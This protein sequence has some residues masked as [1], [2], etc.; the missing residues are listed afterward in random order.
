MQCVNAAQQIKFHSAVFCKSNSH[1]K[2]QL[3]KNHK[4][5][6]NKMKLSK[7]VVKHFMKDLPSL[8]VLYEQTALTFWMTPVLHVHCFIML[9]INKCTLFL[10]FSS[11][12]INIYMTV[13]IDEMYKIKYLF[14][15]FFIKFL[16]IMN[17]FI[18]SKIWR[19]WDL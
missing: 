4:Q 13:T 1:H 19:Q 11:F 16:I 3:K 15:Y 14:I 8:S 9:V 7:Q 17:F 18:K 2:F 5:P 10:Q 6:K 12:K